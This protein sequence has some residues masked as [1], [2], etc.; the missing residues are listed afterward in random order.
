MH[1]NSYFLKIPNYILDS[2]KTL[3]GLEPKKISSSKKVNTVQ[4]ESE[5][6]VK[7]LSHFDFE[8]N[9]TDFNVRT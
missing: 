3:L 1:E 6:Q 8:I 5:I 2:V 9:V 4:K 7:P